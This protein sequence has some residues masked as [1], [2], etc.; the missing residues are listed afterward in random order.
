MLTSFV[1]KFLICIAWLGYELAFSR[2]IYLL[3]DSTSI[4]VMKKGLALLYNCS[5]KDPNINWSVESIQGYNYENNTGLICDSDKIERI[6]Y[7]CVSLSSY[8]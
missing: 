7:H 4:R 5:K 3:G 6:G 1:K 2:S 8:F